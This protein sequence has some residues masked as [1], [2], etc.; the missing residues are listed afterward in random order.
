MEDEMSK[1]KT[2]TCLNCGGLAG[3]ITSGKTNKEM[4][5]NYHCSNCNITYVKPFIGKMKIY[6]HV[7]L[8]QIIREYN[9]EVFAYQVGQAAL[10]ILKES[11]LIN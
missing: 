10:K 11:G 7:T 9:E 3:I 4:K 6:R 2:M 8:S 1:D 5:G